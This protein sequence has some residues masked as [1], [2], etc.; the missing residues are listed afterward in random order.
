MEPGTVRGRPR[1]EGADVLSGP[2]SVAVQVEAVAI[3]RAHQVAETRR[4][5]G[6]VHLELRMGLGL[7]FGLGR[8]LLETVQMQEGMTQQIK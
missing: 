6:Q 1:V 2:G 8:C 5:P 7:A 3:F 4:Q